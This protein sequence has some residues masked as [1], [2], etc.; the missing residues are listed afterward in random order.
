MRVAPSSPRHDHDEWEITGCKL[1]IGSDGLKID[2]PSPDFLRLTVSV[3]FNDQEWVPGALADMSR[4]SRDAF[5]AVNDAA[6][7]FGGSDTTLQAKRTAAD[8]A[9]HQAELAGVAG[10]FKAASASYRKAVANGDDTA[11]IEAEMDALAG[12]KVSLEGRI[13]ILTTAAPAAH[14]AALAELKRVADLKVG[15]IKA[16]ARDDRAA[17]VAEM[18]ERCPDLIRRFMVGDRIYRGNSPSIGALTAIAGLE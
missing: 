9:K 1:P 11:A 18:F 8:L 5:E 2:T 16:A 4:E 15:E 12:R 10:K 6:R 17:A 3:T 14:D 13:G 7:D